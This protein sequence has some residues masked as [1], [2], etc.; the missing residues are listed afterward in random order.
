MVWPSEFV[1]RT[2]VPE[3]ARKLP[4]KV[5]P[6][7]VIDKSPD[8]LRTTLF[9]VVLNVPPVLIARPFVLKRVPALVMLPAAVSWSGPLWDRSPP[10]APISMSPL[11]AFGVPLIFITLCAARVLINWTVPSITALLAWLTPSLW[12]L[13]V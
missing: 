4:D 10:V 6:A 1:F 9:A 3:S 8:E 7:A 11:L 13:T 5:I 12:M 2:T